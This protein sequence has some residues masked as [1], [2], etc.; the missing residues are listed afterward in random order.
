MRPK[1]MGG[2]GLRDLHIF[3]KAL[4]MK[5]I[6]SMGI[7]SEILKFKYLKEACLED[8]YLKGWQNSSVG[9][10]I[11]KGFKNIWATFLSFLK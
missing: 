11:W 7:W 6:T 1:E 9:S 10:I 4:I 3:G 2:W 5:G 8:L